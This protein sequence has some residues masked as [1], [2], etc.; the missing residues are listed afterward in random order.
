LLDCLLYAK[1]L[2]PGHEMGSHFL[3]TFL[4]G[5]SLLCAFALP[6]DVDFTWFQWKKTATKILLGKRLI[7]PEQ[8]TFVWEP[9]F[10]SDIGLLSIRCFSAHHE[11]WGWTFW[12]KFPN[13]DEKKVN[14][15]DLLASL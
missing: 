4:L 9:G 13:A 7:F 11:S 1:G 2:S 10:V 3:E 15:L 12:G 14:V 5:C 8:T 6:K